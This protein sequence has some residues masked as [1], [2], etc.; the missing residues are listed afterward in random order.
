MEIFFRRSWYD[1]E[2]GEKIAEG[3][4][5]EI[6][7][8]SGTNLHD[9]TKKDDLV[10]KVFKEGFSLVD[11][12]RWWPPGLAEAALSYRYFDQFRSDV[13]LYWAVDAQLL[14]GD[15]FA[16]VFKRHWGDICKLIDKRLRRCNGAPPFSFLTTLS[17][18]F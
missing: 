9:G 8:A 5:A 6:F 16:S 13:G 12:Q 1:L 10:V 15:Q 18:L 11:L 4:H 3:G 2:I 7:T 14:E 17:T